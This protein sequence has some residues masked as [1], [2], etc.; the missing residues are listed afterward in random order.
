M[1]LKVV[2]MNYVKKENSDIP[3]Y[4][5]KMVEEYD[6]LRKQESIIVARKKVLA[7]KIKKESKKFGVKDE[8]GNYYADSNEYIFGSQARKSV[9][10][11]ND[12]AIAFFK[13]NGY[14]DCYRIVKKEELDEEAIEARFND[15]DITL[16]DLE[17][18]T[19]TKVTYAIDIRKK[20]EVV[21]IVQQSNIAASNKKSFFNKLMGE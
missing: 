21:D 2:F 10:F 15:G 3:D 12:K 6:N 16:E 5:I 17:E 7:D 14:K 20:E 4:L 13:E 18:I 8:Q 11:D 1:G 19:N 9:S